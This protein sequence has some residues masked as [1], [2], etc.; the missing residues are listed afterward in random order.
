MFFAFGCGTMACSSASPSAAGPADAGAVDAN[1]PAPVDAGVAVVDASDAAAPADCA[2]YCAA[3]L[4]HCNRIGM[5][6]AN[7]EVCMAHCKALPLGSVGD[8]LDTVGCRQA[9]AVAA[10]ATPFAE[11]TLA[12]AFPASGCGSRC[13]AFCKLAT[14]ICGDLWQGHCDQDCQGWLDRDA[15]DDSNNTLDCREENVEHAFEQAGST[16]DAGAGCPSVA[17]D[18]IQCK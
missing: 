13:D 3:N 11:C 7:T 18:S 9:H 12:G 15:Q 8:S 5:G 4:S 6:Y 1:Q 16:D 14:A 10:A 17:T 2:T